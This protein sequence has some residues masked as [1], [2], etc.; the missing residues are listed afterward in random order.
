[1]THP[2]PRPS[3]SAGTCAVLSEK[4]MRDLAIAYHKADCDPDGTGGEG[5]YGCPG[6]QHLVAFLRHAIGTI[7]F[8]APL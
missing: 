8:S 1:M 4:T 2:Q 3:K 6:V 7:T 5:E